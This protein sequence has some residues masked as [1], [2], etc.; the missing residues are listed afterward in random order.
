[1]CLL[2]L[3]F[4][5]SDFPFCSTSSGA[6]RKWCWLT[7]LSICLSINP[8][9]WAPERYLQDRSYGLQRMISSY[10]GHPLTFGLS[11]PSGKEF[12]LYTCNQSFSL[13]PASGQMVSYSYNIWYVFSVCNAVKLVVVV[14][15]PR[16]TILSDLGDPDLLSLPPHSGHMCM[17]P[18]R[19]L[20]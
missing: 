10:F 7:D 12:R 4:M 6:K 19:S 17:I 16:R 15:A 3:P 2:S 14:N 1:M 13:T 18:T 8:T 9:L 11:S 5:S 20:F